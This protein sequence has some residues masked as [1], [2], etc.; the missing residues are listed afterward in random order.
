MTTVT[1]ANFSNLVTANLLNHKSVKPMNQ[2]TFHTPPFLYCPIRSVCSKE[3]NSR[4]RDD[5]RSSAKGPCYDEKL[6]KFCSLYIKHLVQKNCFALMAKAGTARSLLY[7][8]IQFVLFSFTCQ[9]ESDNLGYLIFDM[10]AQK[11]LGLLVLIVLAFT[12]SSQPRACDVA[13][14]VLGIS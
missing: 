4:S 14:Q 12:F 1:F 10:V 3:R 7:L 11:A 13:L 2:Q 9:L 8:L 6:G 5:S